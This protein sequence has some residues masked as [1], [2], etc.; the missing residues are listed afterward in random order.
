M[1]DPLDNYVNSKEKR[2]KNLNLNR[3][4]FLKEQYILE[5]QFE[6]TVN[7]LQDDKQSFI[8]KSQNQ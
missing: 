2:I 5:K 8:G 3:A 6:C 1:T 4:V 7:Y